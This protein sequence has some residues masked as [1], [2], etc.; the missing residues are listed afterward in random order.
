MGS[1]IS[2]P[3]QANNAAPAQDNEKAGLLASFSSL[4]LSEEPPKSADG[5]LSLSNIASWEDAASADSKIEL[6]RTILSH[7][8]IRS[9]LTSRKARV[10]DA[11][12]F[13]TAVDFKTGPITN[14]KSSGRCW[15]FATTNVLRYEIMKKL[16]L[17]DF[18]LSQV[19]GVFE[20]VVRFVF[21]PPTR[22]KCATSVPIL[23]EVMD[24]SMFTTSNL[25]QVYSNLP[26]WHV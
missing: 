23:L 19:C 12:V 20:V 1:V 22:S 11:H 6:A 2:S 3:A 13:N 7:S 10:A 17:E 5:S 14:Q 26:I 15:L 4:S 9:A 25:S 16:K 21:Y 18:Q 24:R 8:D